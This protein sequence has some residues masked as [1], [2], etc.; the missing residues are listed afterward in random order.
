ARDI[1][2]KE[3]IVPQDSCYFLVN[4][5]SPG[6]KTIR[7]NLPEGEYDQLNFVLGVDS[8]RNTMNIS[9]RTG[10]LD[11]ANAMDHGMYWGWNSGYIFFKMEGT[12]LQSP[13][14]PIGQRK[15][16]YHIGGFG[17]YSAPTINNI[18][19]VSLSLSKG[20][21]IKARKGKKSDV[22]IGSDVLKI[23]NGSSAISIAAHSSVM[24]SEY[25][26]NVAN[27]YSQMFSHDNTENG[28]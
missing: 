19:N 21:T 27:N 2:G 5:S 11:P 26:V 12:S 18:K 28:N 13:V 24:F 4:E 3:Y 23:F 20:G 22:F 6:T 14:D 7:V 17:G 9:K 15:F 16:R 8:L 10:V 1:K 25:S